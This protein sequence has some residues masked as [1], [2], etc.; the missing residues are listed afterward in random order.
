MRG[1]LY[2]FP[3]GI[4]FVDGTTQR[5][6]R[7]LCAVRQEAILSGHHHFHCHVA[8]VRTDVFGLIIRLDMTQ[9]GSRHDRGIYNFTEVNRHP[10]QY[11]TGPEH[12]LADTGFQGDGDHIVCPAKS[13]QA[14]GFPLRGAM[15]RDIRKQLIRNKWSVGLV[16]NRFRLF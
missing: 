12:A 3:F 14:R 2:G 6:Y 9:L 11:F 5:A 1:M 16:S 4:V 15:N 7:P 8:L 10:E 13:N